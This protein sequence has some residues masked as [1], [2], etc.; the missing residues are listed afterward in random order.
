MVSKGEEPSS[1]PMSASGA[2]FCTQAQNLGQCPTN[3]DT[4]ISHQAKLKTKVRFLSDIMIPSSRS[5]L[6]ATMLTGRKHRFH[7]LLQ[8][9]SKAHHI[10]LKQNQ[11]ILEL[12][13]PFFG[14]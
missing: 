7:L 10:F 3:I 14:K 2:V 6:L 12:R 1:L 8:L 5:A 11:L 4:L 13:E 9:I